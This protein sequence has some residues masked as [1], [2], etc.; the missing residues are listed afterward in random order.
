MVYFIAE[1]GANHEGSLERAKMLI[2]LAARAGANAAK[3]Q[4]YRA[5]TL[6][7]AAGFAKLASLAHYSDN[8]HSVFRQFEIPWDWTP[9]LADACAK[10]G[11]DFMSTPY[12]LAAVDHLA[13][14]VSRFKIGSGDITYT[15]LIKRAASFNKPVYIGTGASDLKDV[16][17]AYRSAGPDICLMQ[18]NTNYTGDDSNYDSINLR[19]LQTYTEVF[20]G[21]RLGLSDHMTDYGVVAAAIT[22]GATV[23]ERHFTDDRERQGSPDHPFAMEPDMFLDMVYR[24]ELLERALGQTQKRVEPNEAE[25]V[26]LQRR[27][28]RATRDLAP[29][30]PLRAE[31]FAPLRPAPVGALEPWQLSRFVGERLNRAVSEGE[32]FYGEDFV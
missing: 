23:I 18:C 2:G 29:G 3:F 22:L 1:I 27:C 4:H 16:A 19:V 17:R 24:T 11:I 14:Y 8:P 25:T 20:P 5:N 28:L 32:A 31:D 26:V 21:V 30:V 6:A 12:E 10:V 7:S 15:Q 13:P 9:E